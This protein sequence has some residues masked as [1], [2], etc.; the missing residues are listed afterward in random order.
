MKTKIYFLFLIAILLQLKA[1][2]QT[3]QL[4]EGFT[5]P[6][7]FN[8]NGWATQNNSSPTTTLSWFQGSPTVVPAYSGSPADYAGA[9]FNA[10]S[11]TGN[12]SVF[13][14]TPTITI[15]N[16]GVLQFATRTVS[17]PAQYPD[18][19]QV[20]M[21]YGT[22]INVGSGASSVGTF[23][24]TIDDINQNLT[25]TGYPGSWTIYSYTMSGI[26]NA[27]PGRFAFRYYVPGGGPAANY[28]NYIGLDDV[29]YTI[30]PCVPPS[31]TITP[32]NGTVLCGPGA[33]GLV[34]SGATNYTWMPG[35]IEGDAVITDEINSATT[36]TVIGSDIPGCNG[37]AMI[38]ISVVPQPTVSA[39]NVTTCPGSAV[40]LTASGATSYSWSN[41]GSGASISYMP[42]GTFT[43]ITVT[44]YNG[45]GTT[46]SQSAI[47]S[48]SSDT[49]LIVPSSNVTACPGQ[50]AFLGA[51]GA[52]SYNWSTGAQTAS[53]VITPTANASYMVTGTKGSCTESK[54]INL[55]LDPNLFAPS[56]T[57]CSGTAATLIAMGA[58]SYSWSTGATSTM[59]VVPS[60]T[61]TAPAVY[62]IT[63]TSG[64]CA[65]TKTVS[66]SKGLN[67]TVVASQTCSG[68]TA[69]VSAFGATNYTWMPGNDHNSAII[70]PAGS[71]SVYTLTGTSGTCT[72]TA[73]VQVEVCVGIEQWQSS[74]SVNVY[75]NPFSNQLTVA[76]AYGEVQVFNILGKL[77]LSQPVDGETVITTDSFEPG[78]YLLIIKDPQKAER[79][80]IKVLKN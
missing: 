78:I 61:T 60:P 63:G 80:V 10:T 76:N 79:K 49:F 64:S 40:T 45:T 34:A 37:T 29:E 20:L 31:L 17:N 71:T 75:P 50:V 47:V 27:G 74:G 48:V 38:T 52:D 55:T 21:S 58:N 72:G 62:T 44:G 53:I 70:I 3:T 2:A 39:N 25:T 59:I 73:I 46:C 68:T 12:I 66:V 69:I 36:F 5:N 33:V 13:L 65:Q 19:M 30:P 18:R 6:F 67:L 32:Q 41:G 23:T 7:G 15:Q 16:G 28:S 56:F 1:F 26:T 43:T 24:D 54:V 4:N 9:N 35:G 11:G 8:S 14:I 22:G 51:S 77:M 42:A 57:V